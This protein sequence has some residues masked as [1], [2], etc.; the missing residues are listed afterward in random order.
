MIN[1]VVG[2]KTTHLKNFFDNT[3]NNVFTAS[4]G[5]TPCCKRCF[6]TLL[7]RFIACISFPYFFF[8]LLRLDGWSCSNRGGFPAQRSKIPLVAQ[9]FPPS[10]HPLVRHRALPKF[11]FFS[12]LH[13]TKKK[14]YIS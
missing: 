14:T 11:G 10:L 13:D 9:Y 8:C 12:H 1:F 2:L 4:R 6:T 5:H 7:K 3:N